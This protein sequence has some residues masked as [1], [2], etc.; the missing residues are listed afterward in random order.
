MNEGSVNTNPSVPYE[1]QS[2]EERSMADLVRE[3]EASALKQSTTPIE[4]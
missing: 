3:A 1:A 2:L 4:G